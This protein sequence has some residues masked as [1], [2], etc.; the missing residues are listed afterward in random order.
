MKNKKNDIKTRFHTVT[1]FSSNTLLNPIIIYIT[2]TG[3]VFII[4]TFLDIRLKPAPIDILV[5]FHGILFDLIIFG[6]V[7]TLYTL[8]R[9]KKERISN[10]LDQLDD[11]WDWKA[12][13]GVLRK[14]G[15][16][17]RLIELNHPPVVMGSIYLKGADFS[18]VIFEEFNI[19]CSN[20]ENS[21][22]SH[23]EMINCHM[24]HNNF[25]NSNFEFTKFNNCNLQSSIFEN[26]NMHLVK[27]N[28][29]DLSAINFKGADLRQANFRGT[30]LY[31]Y[32]VAEGGWICPDFSGA[33]LTQADFSGVDLTSCI[34]LTKEQIEKARIDKNTKLP[35]Y[36]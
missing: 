15:I 5:E 12:V 8:W 16:M 6:I 20:F 28:N 11:F 10:L 32:G 17:K 2:L 3:I 29:A 30:K 36:L 7:L 31:K 33:N 25:K 9:E 21:N 23:V 1:H 14:V 34:G 4:L 18:G 35:D 22:F 26:S 27:F 19:Y 13:E 24:P